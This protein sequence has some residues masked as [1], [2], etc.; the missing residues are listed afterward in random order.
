MAR[1]PNRV[2]DGHHSLL[3][4]CVWCPDLCCRED[5]QF[6]RLEGWVDDGASSSVGSNHQG[7]PVHRV[8]SANKLAARGGLWLG[9]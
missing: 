9:E 7:A 1:L 3:E 6:H 2:V 8:H 4:G 5:V